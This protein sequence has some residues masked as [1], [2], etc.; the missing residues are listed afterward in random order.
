MTDNDQQQCSPNSTFAQLANK[1]DLRRA[2]ESAHGQLRAMKNP[3]PDEL[4]RGLRQ[5]AHA[6]YY[7]YLMDGPSTESSE[8]EPPLSPDAIQ[9]SIL[10]CLD[11]Y[12]P[13]HGEVR[14]VVDPWH[15]RAVVSA[16]IS[17][18]RL[19]RSRWQLNELRAVRTQL[20][21][22]S[23]TLLD[24]QS[25]DRTFADPEQREWLREVAHLARYI[26]EDEQASEIYRYL[27]KLPWSDTPP[28][29][30]ETVLKHYRASQVCTTLA[31][32]V[33]LPEKRSSNSVNLATQLASVL[34]KWLEP[35]VAEHGVTE[36]SADSGV[37][38]GS[39]PTYLGNHHKHLAFAYR[40]LGQDDQAI[41]HRRRAEQYF[42]DLGMR[43]NHLLQAEYGML[44]ALSFKVKDETT[45]NEARL[46][47][48][49]AEALRRED[50]WQ[51]APRV[52]FEGTI[53]AMRLRAYLI[54]D[55]CVLP[56]WMEA[57][58]KHPLAHPAYKGFM[59]ELARG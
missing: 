5:A 23:E 9:E 11:A 55:D 28:G 59:A 44:Q 25:E 30:K 24:R 42:L 39:F 6:S 7:A 10:A 47:L 56:S 26:G 53:H 50:T 35:V 33:P 12:V 29:Y 15:R 45:R 40:V 41:H 19:Y 8:E 18:H 22:W 16:L 57:A 49:Q 17:R 34:V 43:K 21:A 58:C 1:H 14:S 36:A 32:L 37:T 38:T 20:I 54:Q 13:N 52:A 3:T 31:L 2:I 51:Y 48:A 4:Y 27:R 46:A